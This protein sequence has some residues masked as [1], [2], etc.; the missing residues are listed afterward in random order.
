MSEK[1]ECDY[2]SRLQLGRLELEYVCGIFKSN[3]ETSHVL[4][5]SQSLEQSC[6]NRIIKD[7]KN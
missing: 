5:L 2:F 6:L 3:E 1:M 4:S 7:A